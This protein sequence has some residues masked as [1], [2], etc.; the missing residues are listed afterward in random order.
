MIG[1]HDIHP[2]NR[3]AT[4]CGKSVELKKRSLAGMAKCIRAGWCCPVVVNFA[5]QYSYYIP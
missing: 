4:V 2:K 1:C 5:G 3:S